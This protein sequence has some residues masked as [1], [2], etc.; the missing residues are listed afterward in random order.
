ML[1]LVDDDSAK[2]VLKLAFATN[3]IDSTDIGR[4]AIDVASEQ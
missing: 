1:T 2:S 4:S 3:I